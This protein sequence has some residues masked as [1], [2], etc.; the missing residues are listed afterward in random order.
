[1]MDASSFLVGRDVWTF[2]GTKSNNA[3]HFASVSW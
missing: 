1:M 2:H 3:N